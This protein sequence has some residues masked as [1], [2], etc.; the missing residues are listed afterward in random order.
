MDSSEFRQAMALAK[1]IDQ[2]MERVARHR[3]HCSQ[4]FEDEQAVALL[5]R[6][7]WP[8]SFVQSRISRTSAGG[9]KGFL[10]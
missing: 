1:R 3:I 9:S 4:A 10:R 2:M 6:R 5:R 8:Q 7:E